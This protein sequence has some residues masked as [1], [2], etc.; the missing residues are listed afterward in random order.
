MLK[1]TKSDDA[2]LEVFSLAKENGLALVA[3]NA[4]QIRDFL[5]QDAAKKVNV[6]LHSADAGASRLLPIPNIDEAVK[7]G[8]KVT[9]AGTFPKMHEK[10]FELS[11]IRQKY[12]SM[13]EGVEFLPRES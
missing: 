2:K 9:A 11:L 13:E 3:K 5:G 12:K 10:F 7:L 8:Q 1:M 4:R 6:E